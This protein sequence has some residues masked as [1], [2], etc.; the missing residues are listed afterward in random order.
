MKMSLFSSY[1]GLSALFATVSFGLPISGSIGFTGPYGTNAT[2]LTL[3]TE[4]SFNNAIPPALA[5]QTDVRVSG[6]R[7][8][9][10]SGIAVGTHVT[11]FTP[12][13][14]NGVGNSIVLPD[15]PIWSVGGFTLTLTS[16][17]ETFNDDST[18]NVRGMGI[19]S[20]GDTAND[21]VGEWIATF[22][23]AGDNFTFSASS[24]AVPDSGTTAVFLGFALL[25]IAGATRRLG[26]AC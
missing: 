12:L 23:T 15:G 7:T 22:N 9:S 13:Q 2:D 18:L 5:E 25:L 14:V 6:V 20:M 17:W 24:A 26:K 3:A 10:F 21:S 19:F 8:G 4:I 11:M 16:I 1:L